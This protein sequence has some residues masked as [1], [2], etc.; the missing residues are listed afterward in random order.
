MNPR[1]TPVDPARAQGPAKDLLAAVQAKLGMTPNLMRT[2][3]HSP[4][5]LEGYLALNA[6]LAKGVLRAGV[7]EQLALAVAQENRCEYCLAAHTALGKHAGLNPDQI[8]AARKLQSADAKI[9]AQL[10]LAGQIVENRGELTDGQ[11]SAAREAG[12]SEAEIAE[13][14][15]H[16]ALNVLTNYINLVAR[17]EVDFPKVALA[18]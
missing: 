11:L 5:A 7:R 16:V 2:L 17:T 10:Q 1:I 14:V 8:A 3:A 12:V 4:A 6:A 13:I 18:Q 15:A 9:R